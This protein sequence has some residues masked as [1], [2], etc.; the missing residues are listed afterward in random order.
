MRRVVISGGGRGIGAAAV[1]L[2]SSMG[3]KVVFFYKND[4][5]AAN[6]LCHKTG[7]A[8]IKTDVSCAE[9]GINA[10]NKALELLGGLDIIVLNAGIAHIAQI[11]D[12]SN[13]DWHN[14]INTN[15]S[16]VF[17]LAREASSLMVKKHFGRIITVGSIW[18]KCGASCEVAYSAS[19][20]GVRGLTMALA[21]ELGPSGIT[22]NCVE[23]GLIFTDMN[24]CL[25]DEALASICDE[26]P[27][28]RM[29]EAHEVA[30]LIAFLA[31]DKASYI[32]GQCIGVDGGWGV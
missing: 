2:F 26:I 24:K 28:G 10:L 12:T 5:D 20:A 14:I 25:D 8:A 22:V 16:S 13:G 32:N 1:E 31:S 17:Y 9:N 29:G 23:P 27:A 11:C 6:A 7:A 4:D 30:E 19:K 15:L 18:G 21:K 3:D